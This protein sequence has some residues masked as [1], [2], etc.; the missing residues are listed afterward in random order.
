M[1]EIFMHEVMFTPLTES[2]DNMGIKA[3]SVVYVSDNKETDI[4]LAALKAVELIN[5]GAKVTHKVILTGYVMTGDAS[6]NS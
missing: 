3:V 1:K 2:T 6:G 5:E 4:F